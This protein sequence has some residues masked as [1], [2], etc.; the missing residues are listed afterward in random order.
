[1]KRI[2]NERVDLNRATVGAVSALVG[3]GFLAKTGVDFTNLAP[4]IASQPEH[5]TSLEV[6]AKLA[7]PLADFCIA[8]GLTAFGQV[9]I[10]Q[11]V[12]EA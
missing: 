5:Q 7:R 1:M 11:S 2:G 6:S 8:L 4:V 3:F 10:A 9:Q 12:H